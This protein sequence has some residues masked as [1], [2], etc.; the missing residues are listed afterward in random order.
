MSQASENVTQQFPDDSFDGD[1]TGRQ[2]IYACLTREVS[3][4]ISVF[5][6]VS[7]SALSVDAVFFRRTCDISCR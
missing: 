4:A 5:D 7:G 1:L 3:Y 6:L 2:F